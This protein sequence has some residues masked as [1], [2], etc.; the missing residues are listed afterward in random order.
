MSLGFVTLGLDVLIT[1]YGLIGVSH[2]KVNSDVVVVCFCSIY[3]VCQPFSRALDA[4]YAL[5]I[6]L[7]D[8]FFYF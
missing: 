3:R 7:S 8:H 5:F 6:I 4:P 1:S 2:I